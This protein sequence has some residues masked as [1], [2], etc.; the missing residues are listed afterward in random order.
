MPKQEKR[1]VTCILPS[2]YPKIVFD[3]SGECNICNS[4]KKKWE[5]I[6]F[7]KREKYLDNKL[8]KFRGKTKPYDCIVGLS[9]GKDSCFTAYILKKKGMQP[10]AVTFDNCFMTEIA[11][12]NI[13]ETVNSLSLG[14]VV[15]KHSQNYIQ[16][17]YRQFLLTAG[18]FCSVC[19]VG[20]RVA[21]YQTAKKHNIKLIV[22]GRSTRTEANNPKEFFTCSPGYFQNVAQTFL[23]RK[24]IYAFMYFNQIQRAIWNLRKCPYYIELPNYLP[25]KEEEMFRIMNKKLNWVGSSGEQHSDCK[26]NNAKE[27]L[28]LKKFDVPELVAKLSS[29]IRDNQISRDE[30]LAKAEKYINFLRENEKSIR[31]EIKITF[32][33][34]DNQLDKSIRLSHLP[35]IDIILSK[36][37]EVY[38]K[39]R[40]I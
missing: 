15:I 36:I 23:S 40:L 33:I 7:R 16:N 25:W 6:N 17:Y 22:S 34:S 29:L 3:E 9:G 5:A 4:W 19:N 28:K 26:M 12:H 38:E 21:L 11:H 27:Y 30:A 14:H 20:I 18:E 35:Y 10:L 2:K 32:N 24:E 39:I 8:N 37:K 1:C 13:N 31:E